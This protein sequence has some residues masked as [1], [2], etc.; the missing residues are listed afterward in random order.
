MQQQ[1]DVCKINLQDTNFAPWSRVTVLTVAGATV[2]YTN[3]GLLERIYPTVAP[4]T[5]KTV[6]L[7]QGAKL[8]SCKLI[9]Q[10]SCCCCIVVLGQ[11]IFL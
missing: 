4:A 9:L 6:T 1:H 8:V 3:H 5:V 7:D 11:Y 2:G 10:T